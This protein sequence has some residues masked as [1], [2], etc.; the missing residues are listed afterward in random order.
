MTSAGGKPK[1]NI[2]NPAVAVESPSSIEES[3]ERL[4]AAFRA[5]EAA[6][7][8]NPGTGQLV[9]MVDPETGHCEAKFYAAPRPGRREAKSAIVLV[10]QLEDNDGQTKLTGL[11]WGR[12]HLWS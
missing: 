12:P 4:L 5:G 10:G 6:A 1:V 8:G 2:Q 9:G 11:V 3:R 7:V